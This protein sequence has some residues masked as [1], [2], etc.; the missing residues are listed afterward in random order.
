MGIGMS[1]LVSRVCKL[2]TSGPSVLDPPE[3]FE[4]VRDKLPRKKDDEWPAYIVGASFGMP[5]GMALSQNVPGLGELMGEGDA[6]KAQ[7]QY[8]SIP[9]E[10]F[11]PKCKQE[12]ESY[13]R[14]FR[15]NNMV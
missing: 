3:D 13:I 9:L 12:W 7:H 8:D 5:M 1:I 6:L 14:Y 2:R 10:M 15:D 4:L 11:L